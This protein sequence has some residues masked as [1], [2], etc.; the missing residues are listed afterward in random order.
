[1]SAVSGNASTDSARRP[2]PAVSAWARALAARLSALFD[3]D[4]GIAGRLNDA[5]HR[6]RHANERLWSGLAQTLSG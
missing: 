3:A 2:G 4:C 6:L 5:Q 1:M